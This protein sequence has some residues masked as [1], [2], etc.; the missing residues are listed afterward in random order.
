MIKI[1]LSDTDS[2]EINGIVISGKDFN[3]TFAHLLKKKESTKKEPHPAFNM[4][5]T[6]YQEKYKEYYWQAIDSTLLNKIIQKITFAFEQNK[7]IKPTPKQ[8]YATWTTV[9]N[10]LPEWYVQ[11]KE[12]S[13][14]TIN[15]KW[16]TILDT[17]R[18][19]LETKKTDKTISVGLQTNVYS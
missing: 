11:N 19:S 2:I 8:V 16:Q 6:F 1:S 4:M 12:T 3:D 14:A 10:N 7:N 17:V 18:D 5:K 15:K 13:I 9:L